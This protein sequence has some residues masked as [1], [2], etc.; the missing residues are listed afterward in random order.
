MCR[1]KEEHVH[2]SECYRFKLA[3]S[4]LEHRIRQKEYEYKCHGNTNPNL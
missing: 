4:I 3:G 2:S 1:G